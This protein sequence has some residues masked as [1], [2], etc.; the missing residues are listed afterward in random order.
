M[1]KARADDRRIFSSG[2]QPHVLAIQD[3]KELDAQQITEALNVPVL[4][5]ELLPSEYLFEELEEE[6]APLFSRK[7]LSVKGDIAQANVAQLIALFEHGKTFG[8]LIRVP[9]ELAEQ[10]PAIAERVQDVS[11]YGG[12]LEQAAARSLRPL[13]EQIRI[14]AD[15]YER[16]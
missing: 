12:M 7:N 2:I 15:R 3:S 13:I 8:S 16:L 4:K 5:T 6:R 9:E 14:L 11:A 10:L 1:M